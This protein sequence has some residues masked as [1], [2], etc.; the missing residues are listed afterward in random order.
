MEIVSRNGNARGSQLTLRFRHRFPPRTVAALPP[1]PGTTDQLLQRV[2]SPQPEPNVPEPHAHTSTEG[3]GSSTAPPPSTTPASTILIPVI[4]VGIRTAPAAMLQEIG[5]M[6]QDGSPRASDEVERDILPNTPRSPTSWLNR[7]RRS[8]L[9][10]QPGERGS[11]SFPLD[12]EGEEEEEI[13]MAPT[14]PVQEA[15]TGSGTAAEEAR[16]PSPDRT[17][18]YL[19]WVIGKSWIYVSLRVWL[20]EV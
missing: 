10:R 18:N 19:I 4:V 8:M 16:L 20:T 1:A 3:A 6:T 13:P 5:N 9:R 2:G 15:P 7:F 12:E 17:R 14:P 11:A